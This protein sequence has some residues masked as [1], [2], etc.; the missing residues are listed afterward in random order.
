MKYYLCI[1]E[2][3]KDGSFYIGQTQNVNARLKKHNAGYNLATK[4]KRPWDLLFFAEYSSRSESM[5]MEKKLK[6]FKKR[7][8]IIDFIRNNIEYSSGPDKL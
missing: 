6:A 7:D 2:S 5:K 1:L 4:S 8:A 3:I